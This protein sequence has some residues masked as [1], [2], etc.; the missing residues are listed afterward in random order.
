MS[1]KTQPLATPQLDELPPACRACVFWEVAGAPAGPPDAREGEAVAALRRSAKEAWWQEAVVAGAAPAVGAYRDEQLV[2]YALV[3]TDER[4]P[5][6]PELGATPSVDAL[7][8]ATLWVREDER[9]AG[10][11]S[12]LL[13]AVLRIAHEQGL[14]AVEAFGRRPRPPLAPR[15][16][17]PESFL[18][19]CGFQVIREHPVTPLL[20]V[21]LRQTARW[22]E[23]LEQALESLVTVLRPRQRA[24]ARPAPEA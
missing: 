3:S 9:G 4:L 18:Q 5:R 2:G 12:R 23:S 10:V 21:E 16:L 20:R 7:F 1:A 19:A 13:Q 15:C 6:P 11:G 22:Q 17:V 14:A 8:L 24:P